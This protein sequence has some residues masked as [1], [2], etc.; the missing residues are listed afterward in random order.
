[1]G[2]R[3]RLCPGRALHRLVDL[4][5][6]V[7]VFFFEIV[8]QH[9]VAQVQDVLRTSAGAL[10]HSARR[11]G[12]AGRAQPHRVARRSLGEGGAEAV[13]GGFQHGIV[14]QKRRIGGRR[15][16]TLLQQ[17]RQFVADQPQPVA[18]MRAEPRRRDPDLPIGREPVDADL[19]GQA[20]DMQAHRSAQRGGVGRAKTGKQRI[21]QQKGFGFEIR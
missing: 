2:G 21:R 12:G 9:L 14:Q 18:G 7:L 17:M 5:L 10:H 6:F 1:M 20:G 15:H 11:R 19:L 8:L 4:V 3:H 16:R 13:G